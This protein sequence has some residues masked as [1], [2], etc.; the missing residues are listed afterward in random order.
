MFISAF[1]C[2]I[3]CGKFGIEQSFGT[4]LT[5][6]HSEGKI[7]RVLLQCYAIAIHLTLQDLPDIIRIVANLA[8]ICAL[9][10]FL[11]MQNTA[12]ELLN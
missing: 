1:S 10:A 4:P 3:P 11:Y 7:S 2:F 8:R 12:V 5:P 6:A 9:I